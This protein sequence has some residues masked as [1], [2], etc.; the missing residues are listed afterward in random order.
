M[1]FYDKVTGHDM[2]KLQVAYDQR[3]AKLP[4]DYQRVW[5]E[6]NQKIWQFSDFSG[7]NLYPVLADVVG[8]FE[9]SAAEGLTASA[10][11]GSSLNN[12][13]TEL[14]HVE[15]AKDYRDKLRARLNETVA[16]K[17]EREGTR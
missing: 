12:F 5:Q 8:L 15:G 1:N 2:T 7:R 11:T 13:I 10:V 17:L 3:I 16:K 6:L 9:E 14:A 4:Q